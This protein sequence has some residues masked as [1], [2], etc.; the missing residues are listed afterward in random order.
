MTTKKLTTLALFTALALAIFGI[1]CAIPTLVPIPGVKLGLANIIT[2]VV[3]VRYSGK[4]AFFV[5]LARI[6]L[7]T[8]L[9]GQAMSLL[10]SLAGGFLCLLAM[11]CV[12]RLLQGHF[13]CLTS[14]VGALFHNLGQI[15]IALL[16]TATPGVLS[17]LPFLLLSGII[18]GLFTGLCAQFMNNH[19][20]KLKFDLL[21]DPKGDAG[22]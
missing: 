14:M 11:W 1:E 4:D 12:N 15:L 6:L 21:F 9:F 8:L 5:M 22:N 10:Y 20:K 18:T 16:L 13:L 3:L 17:Y 19:L 2:L 7:G